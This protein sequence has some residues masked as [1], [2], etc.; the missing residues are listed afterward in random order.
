M[1][2]KIWIVS[3]LGLVVGLSAPVVGQEAV[4]EPGIQNEAPT[5]A[6]PPTAASTPPFAKPL[7][8]PAPA[9]PLTE[10]SSWFSPRDYPTHAGLEGLEGTSGFQVAVESN[11]RVSECLIT[12]SSGHIILDKATC[13]GLRRR[14]RFVPAFDADG[15]AIRGYYSGV[16]QWKLPKSVVEP[17][18]PRLKNRQLIRP[19]DYPSS[20]W[21]AGETGLVRYVVDVDSKGVARK[22]QIARSSRSASLDALTCK[23]VLERAEFNPA[24]TAQDEPTASTYIG[25]HSWYGG[26]PF[27]VGSMSFV[28]RYEV[29]EEG[30]ARDCQILDLSGQ[31]SES[32][33]NHLQGEKCFRHYS[34]G[35]PHR[36][37]NGVPVAK[38]VTVDM[39]ITVEDVPE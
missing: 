2:S 21:I 36:D 20:A 18:Q 11:G 31:V 30:M 7:V 4:E 3:A 38:T 6:P 22:C 24:T 23:L 9:Q 12:T 33:R 10:P 16:K 14:A 15:N 5:P 19:S 26:S 25:S 34:R 8:L 28:T 39:K 1:K 37:K 32:M 35:A 17:R 29:D 27:I 13:A